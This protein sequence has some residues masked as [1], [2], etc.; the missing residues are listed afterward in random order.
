MQL[1]GASKFALKALR[2]NWGCLVVA[3]GIIGQLGGVVSWCSSWPGLE[4]EG[5]HQKKKKGSESSGYVASADN[6]VKLQ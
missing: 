2:K 6:E 5:S 4:R 3:F 1:E